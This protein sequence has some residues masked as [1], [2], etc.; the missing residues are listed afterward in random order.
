MRSDEP[1]SIR[2]L[3]YGQRRQRKRAELEAQIQRQINRTLDPEAARRADEY[4]Q[5]KHEEFMSGQEAYR[6]WKNSMTPKDFKRLQKNYQTVAA[7]RVARGAPRPVFF[8]YRGE[9][10]PPLRWK[11]R[12][13]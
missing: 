1:G 12:E 8:K 4:Y 3:L 11:Y 13:D 2:Y 9:E 6:S 7:K 10:C 5:A